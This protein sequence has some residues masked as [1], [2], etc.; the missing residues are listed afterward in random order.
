MNER[1]NSLKETLIGLFGVDVTVE[2]HS[3]GDWRNHSITIPRQDG[4][5]V[6]ISDRWTG[7]MLDEWEGWRVVIEDET[8]ILHV[9]PL[10]K[11][12]ADIA[13][14]VTEALT[15]TMTEGR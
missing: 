6:Y 3:R 1:W 11:D 5:S 13:Q 2:G 15:L 12:S 8:C 14:Y 4:I 10:S 7:K 9:W